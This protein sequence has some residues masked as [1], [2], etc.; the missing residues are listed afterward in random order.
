MELGDRCYTCG[1]GP[2]PD[3]PSMMNRTERTIIAAVTAVICPASLFFLFWWI[4]AA[5][6]ISGMLPLSEGWIAAAAISGLC[7]G[8]VLDILCLNRW[9]GNFYSINTK[10]LLLAYLFWSAVAVALLMGLPFLNIALGILAG[11]YMGRK[12]YHAGSARDTFAK[13]ARNVSCFTTFV[14]GAEALPIGVLALGEDIGKIF[15]SAVGLVQSVAGGPM[16]IPLVIVICVL[17]MV[18]QYWCTR[19]AARFAFKLGAPAPGAAAERS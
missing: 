6:S 3:L 10:F 19:A 13:T 15:G 5:L 14:T 11:L 8:A 17:L 16:G 12:Q 4:S 2:A 18:A 1:P 9:I 7:L